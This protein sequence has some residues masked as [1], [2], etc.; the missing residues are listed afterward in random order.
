MT[1]LSE[2]PAS[3]FVED[4]HAAQT[5]ACLE[6]VAAS[7]ALQF[8]LDPVGT[9]RARAVARQASFSTAP[10][11][12]VEVTTVQW[13]SSGRALSARAYRPETHAPDRNPAVFFF[14][15]GGFVSGSLDAVDRQ[16]RVLCRGCGVA[17][18][19]FAYSLAPEHPFPAAIEDALGAITWGREHL[20]ALR[21]SP[22]PVVV[23]GDSAGGN[24]AAVAAQCLARFPLHNVIGQLLIYPVLDL[25]NESW[26]YAAHAV[27]PTLT[28]ERM[29]WYASQ[30]ADR[31]SRTDVRV[32]PSLTLNLANVAPALIISAEIDPLLGE[33]QA[34]ASAL[35]QR[36][37][38]VEHHVFRGLC[39]G[40]WNWG[41]H[42]D[43]VAHASSIAINWLKQIGAGRST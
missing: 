13:E 23:A 12:G 7:N 34:Y 18:I 4:T 40:F 36:G 39:H 19:S 33:A 2:Q 14:H 31:A 20:A 32:S 15:G 27:T 6:R 28:S 17:V 16:C 24:L 26:S 11:G 25:H 9:L 37:I 1:V 30:Y 21:G 5:A 29:R 22:P 38:G 42:H 41:E 35:R 3:H 10:I 43:A 8:D